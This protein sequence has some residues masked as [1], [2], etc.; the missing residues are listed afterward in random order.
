M[1]PVFTYPKRYMNETGL[2]HAD[3]ELG[4]SRGFLPIYA[5]K[6]E[7]TTENLSNLSMWQTGVKITAPDCNTIDNTTKTL[8]CQHFF[9]FFPY[10]CSISENS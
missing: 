10:Y 7:A 6:Q 8:S 2:F 9:A 5:N 3:D 4:I 1:K